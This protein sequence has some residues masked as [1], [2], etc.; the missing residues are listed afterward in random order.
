[1]VEPRLRRI[2][3][4]A[5]LE[6]LPRRMV[7]EP[8]PLVGD[9]RER[10]KEDEREDDVLSHDGGDSKATA[11][12]GGVS[13]G[14]EVGSLFVVGDVAAGFVPIVSMATGGGSVVVVGA[15]VATVAVVSVVT[16]L[17]VVSCCLQAARRIR[18]RKTIDFFM[19]TPLRS[20]WR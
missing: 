7:E 10:E 19:S 17:F 13:A 15:T 1:M 20:T 18:M 11:A 4:V 9:E 5:L 14:G 12:G 3:A 6:D 16:V 2:E 8:H